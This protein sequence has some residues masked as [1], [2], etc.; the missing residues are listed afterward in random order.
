MPSISWPPY[1]F[2][3][4]IPSQPLWASFFMNAR[5]S[6]VS[7]SWVK[8]SRVGSITTGSWFSTSHFST[9]SANACSWGVKSKST[10]GPT[11]ADSIRYAAFR[12]GSVTTASRCTTHRKPEQRVPKKFA[13]DDLQRWAQKR[14]ELVYAMDQGQTPVLADTD[15][16]KA[17]VPAPGPWGVAS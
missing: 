14:G 12:N 10:A 3:H 9:S 5:R 13:W 7:A 17:D 11:S 8:F 1:C 15:P 2:G 16:G 4:D 6:G